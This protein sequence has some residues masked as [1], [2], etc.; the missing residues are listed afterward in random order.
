M[1]LDKNQLVIYKIKNTKIKKNNNNNQ[2]L[3]LFAIK[4]TQLY[5]IHNV[6]L[7]K[8]CF[9]KIKTTKEMTKNL[10]RCVN[11]LNRIETKRFFGFFTFVF[12]ESIFKTQSI[13]FIIKYYNLYIPKDRSYI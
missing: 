9:C 8:S 11:S 4:Q 2:Q 12:R 10:K 6:F 5:Y 1:E 7:K 3:L 13:M